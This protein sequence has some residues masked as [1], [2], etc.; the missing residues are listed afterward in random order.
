MLRGEEAT[1]LGAT[2]V[3]LLNATSGN[4]GSNML[5][6]TYPCP[7]PGELQEITIEESPRK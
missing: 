2:H 1:T 4:T 6:M 5:G 7:P 3:L